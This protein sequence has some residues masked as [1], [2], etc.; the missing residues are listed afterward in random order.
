[1]RNTS[2]TIVALRATFA[3][4]CGC[5]LFAHRAAAQGYSVGASYE[6]TGN[7]L[8]GPSLDTGVQSIGPLAQTS[9]AL[10]SVGLTANGSGGQ[11]GGGVL[12]TASL[13]TLSVSAFADGTDDGDGSADVTTTF[14][15]TLTITSQGLAVG[16]P[17]EFDAHI[18]MRDSYAFELNDTPDNVQLNATFGGFGQTLT[19]PD[20]ST[21]VMLDVGQQVDIFG[22]LGASA[23][24]VPGSQVFGDVSDLGIGTGGC[25]FYFTPVD[26]GSYVS[27]SGYSYS[28]PLDGIGVGVPILL[29][30]P[31]PPSLSMMAVLFTACGIRCL[32]RRKTGAESSA[33][34]R[35]PGHGIRRDP[36]MSL[37][38]V[39]Q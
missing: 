3:A 5:L 15:D 22:S 28:N 30:A 25:D 27:A 26:G 32:W 6:L 2:F 29:A 35:W 34:M 21:T 13:G 4:S 14:T 31:E 39:Q 11:G 7:A 16:T 12:G 23:Q 38:I 1:M 19:G 20:S 10:A 24:A 9:Y 33:G 18:Y 37:A 8:G 17:V 36:A